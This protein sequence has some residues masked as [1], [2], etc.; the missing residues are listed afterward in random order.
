MTPS[1]LIK[2]LRID[3][4][5]HFRLAACSRSTCPRWWAGRLRSVYA[6]ESAELVGRDVKVSVAVP[7][8]PERRRA[9]RIAR[10]RT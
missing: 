4:P 5:D 7:N 10:Y 6:A 8:L 9:N 3:D 2:R 1:K